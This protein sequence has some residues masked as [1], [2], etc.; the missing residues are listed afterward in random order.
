MKVALVHDDFTQAG[1]AESLFATI[2]NLYPKAPIYTSLVDW[3]KVP[4]SIDQS[5]IITSWIQK[6]PQ[7]HK[8]YKALLPFYPLA[9]ESFNFNKFDLVISSTT[10]FAKGVI[11]KPK[12]IHVCYI[13]SVPRFLYDKKSQI[14]YL[15][16]IFQ[17]LLKPCLTWLKRW[18]QASSNRVDRYISNSQ[19]VAGKIREVYSKKS[20]IIYPFAD[21]EFFKP[22]EVHNWKLKSQDYLLVVSRLV[23]WKKIDI[24]IK[25]CASAG[26]NLKIIG[27]GPDLKRLKKIA[28]SFKLSE[29]G[30]EFL[31]RVSKE[32]LRELYQNSH[33]S[34]VTQEEDFGISVVEAQACGVP[35]LAYIL[36]GQAEIIIDGKTGLYFSDQTEKSLEDAIERLSKLKWT[37]A[38]CRKNAENFSRAVF[39]RKLKESIKS[40]ASKQ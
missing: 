14:D 36:G 8:F 22:A 38:N 10:R 9:F 32:N 13:N 4:E 29:S 7:A 40:Y 5:R 11:T 19:N 34:V 27:A 26:I 21:I 23:R 25:A 39:V 31:G 6:I 35:V 3:E 15:P 16:A 12:T 28:S 37:I 2:A 30:V 33:A 20:Q 1:G 24:A 18:D 17:Y